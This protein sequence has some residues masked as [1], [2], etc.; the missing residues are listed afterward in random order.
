M[1]K[2]LIVG[3][4]N[5]G[6]RY[7]EGL[8]LFKASLS[9]DIE[10]FDPIISSIS[11]S[12]EFCKRN[13]IDNKIGKLGYFN[14]IEETTKYFD[15]AIVATTSDVRCKISEYLIKHKQI[16]MLILEKVLFQNL[17]DYER[18]EKLLDNS[19]IK[20]WVNHPRRLFPFYKK[21]KDSFEKK[22]SIYLNVQGGN[23]GIGC[24]GLHFID[25]LSYFVNSQEISISSKFLDNKIYPSKREGFIEFSGLLTG[26]VGNSYFSLFSSKED[27]PTILTLST[28]NFDLTISE[29]K[30]VIQKRFK[31]GDLNESFEKEKIVYFQSEITPIMLEDL[32]N[33][34]SCNLPTYR[35][36]SQ[37]HAVF[38]ESLLRKYNRITS[39]ESISL[40]IT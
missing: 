31:D 40:P 29:Q 25:L 23:W 39:L 5:L 21:L 30:G 8:S 11:K 34:K 12:K 22:E 36:A 27:S 4:G 19:S 14:N 24:N 7:L 37:L 18:F 1:I 16:E 26:R 6:N 2:I 28:N 38:V 3:I 33:N 32:I 35:Q 17:S 10:I 13:N 15:L 9:L 20:C